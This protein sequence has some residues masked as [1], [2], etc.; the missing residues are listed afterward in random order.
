MDDQWTPYREAYE[1][2]RRENPLRI[3]IHEAAHAVAAYHHRYA[4]DSVSIGLGHETHKWLGP[5]AGRVRV[6]PPWPHED[7]PDPRVLWSRLRTTAEV[8]VAGNVA[9]I[10]C[11]GLPSQRDEFAALLSEYGKLELAVCH[12]FPS[13]DEDRIDAYIDAA[14]ARALKIIRANRDT[15]VKLAQSLDAEKVLE[16]PPLLQ[17]LK[18]IKR[19]RERPSDHD[20]DTYYETLWGLM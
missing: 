14:E 10:E 7:D 2:D 17:L 15:L 18:P 16:G 8:M 5:S 20:M 12:A 11:L 3:P 4:V 19:R 13:W 9:E 6:S 1:R